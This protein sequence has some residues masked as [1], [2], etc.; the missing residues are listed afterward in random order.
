M[1]VAILHNAV[2]D[3]APPEDQDTLIQVNT[4]RAALVRLGHESESL[5]CTLNLAAL[6]DDLRRLRPDVVF[7]LVESLAEADSLPY[8]PLAV[9]DVLGLPYT[10]GRTEALFLTTHKLLAKERLRSA[11]L[12]TPDWAESGKIIHEEHEEHE[13]RREQMQCSSCSS[14]PSWIFLL[15]SIH[16]GVGSPACRSRS[17]ASSLWVVR[18]SDSVRLPVYGRPSTSNTADGR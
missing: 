15:F 1:R 12:P 11:G 2:P 9:L 13:E 6:Y 17:L 4:V 8:L 3:N 5:S 14:C 16:A 7:N 10:G 18:K